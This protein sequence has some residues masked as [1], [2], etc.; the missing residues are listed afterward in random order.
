MDLPLTYAL[1]KVHTVLPHYFGRSGS[2]MYSANNAS[3]FISPCH[4]IMVCAI[5]QDCCLV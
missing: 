5:Y 3:L 4:Q 1:D 2:S